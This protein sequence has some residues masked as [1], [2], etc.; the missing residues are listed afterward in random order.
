[1][2]PAQRAQV[3][4]A[5]QP[6]T[7]DDYL[8]LQARLLRSRLL[9]VRRLLTGGAAQAEIS[10]LTTETGL[11][12]LL[13]GH[14]PGRVG[15]VRGVVDTSGLAG[16]EPLNPMEVILYDDLLH[17]PRYREGDTAVVSFEAVLGVIEVKSN[18][19]T[20]RQLGGEF[21]RGLRQIGRLDV[22]HDPQLGL[23]TPPHGYLF[24]FNG[25]TWSTAQAYLAEP[26]KALAGVVVLQHDWCWVRDR[27]D[28]YLEN[29]FY[30]FYI[31]LLHHL[32]TALDISLVGLPEE[33]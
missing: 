10:G 11:R 7:G 29:G 20:D 26:P 31:R 22:L 18:A 1:L 23:P 9:L 32:R 17:A 28:P 5:V 14:L 6:V 30:R 2:S 13:R 15:I 33:E 24:V 3:W 21:G 25:P 27:Q 16:A 12:D 19:T 4:E 8:A